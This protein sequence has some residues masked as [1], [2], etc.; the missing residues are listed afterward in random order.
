MVIY[1]SVFTSF[2]QGLLLLLDGMC[3]QTNLDQ[4]QIAEN[5][6]LVDELGGVVPSFPLPLSSSVGVNLNVRT[7]RSPLSMV[8]MRT[9]IL[10]IV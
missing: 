3:T 10:Q 4:F 9:V 6:T 7:A 8:S 2:D 5:Q 1:L